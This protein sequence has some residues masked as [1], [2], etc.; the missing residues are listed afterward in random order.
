[1]KTITLLLCIA[2]FSALASGSVVLSHFEAF[3]TDHQVSFQWGTSSETGNLFFEIWR[4]DTARVQ[5]TGHGTTTDPHEYTW[6]DT[7]PVNETRYRYTL[8]CASGTSRDSIASVILVPPHWVALGSLTAQAGN[9]VIQLNWLVLSEVNNVRFEIFRNG[10][11][12]VPIV[13]HGNNNNPHS[14][15]WADTAVSWGG[16][17]TYSLYAVNVNSAHDS[18]GSTSI[19]LA[20]D[21]PRVAF[22]QDFR[23]SV[24]PNPFNPATT[25][26]FT[27]PSPQ[28]VRL[29][30]YDISGREQRLLA[31]DLFSAGTHRLAFDASALPSGIYFA[32]LSGRNLSLTQKLLLLK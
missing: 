1:M 24:F 18:L 10:I 31:D 4:D 22:P 8:F 20:A 5:I 25:L 28:R 11:F 6:V 9:L 13:G 15:S 2:L 14:Y 16:L 27:L 3:P 30:I 19:R 29:G 32:H 17:Y 26:S 21:N 23:L 7:T 12:R